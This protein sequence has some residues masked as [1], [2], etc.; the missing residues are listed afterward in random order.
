MKMTYGE[1]V[2][3]MTKYN[4]RGKESVL[5]VKTN[6]EGENYALYKLILSG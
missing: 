1:A 3:L 5:T 4:N 6:R 2:E